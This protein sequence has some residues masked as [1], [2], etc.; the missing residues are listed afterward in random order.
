VEPFFEV[1]KHRLRGALTVSLEF[2]NWSAIFTV[3]AAK[4]PFGLTA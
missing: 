4:A 1:G 2:P 3:L